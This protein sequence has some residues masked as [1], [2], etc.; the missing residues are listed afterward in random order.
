MLAGTLRFTDLDDFELGHSNLE[1]AMTAAHEAEAGELGAFVLGCMGFHARYSGKRKEAVDLI[2]QARHVAARVA[3]PLTR[4]G[5]PPW[6]P[7][8][9]PSPGTL[10]PP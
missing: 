3:S 4:A 9:M 1:L 7:R 8:S 2:D 10:R 6:P 5:L